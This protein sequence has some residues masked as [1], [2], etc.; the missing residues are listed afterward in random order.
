MYLITG[1]SG[2]LGTGLARR[3][4]V[5]CGIPVRIF[6]LRAGR[7]LPAGAEFFRGDMREPGDVARAVEGA[8]T[9]FHLASFLPCARAGKEFYRVNVEGT[10]NLMEACRRSGVERVVY[11]SSSSVYGLPAELPLKEDSPVN[12]AG[13][14]GRSKLL[15]EEVC[16]GYASCGIAVPV[17]RPRFIVGPGRLGLLE[18]IFGWVR[19]N[20]NVYTIGRGDNRFQMVGVED[21]IDAC[22]LA[23]ASGRNGVYNIGA[24]GVPTVRELLAGL[25]RHARSSSALVPLNA[26]AVKLGMRVLDA[27]NLVPFS[28]EQY[29]LADREY[30]LDT[31]KA[32]KELG[33]SPKYTHAAAFNAAYDWYIGNQSG[34]GEGNIS[35]HPPEKILRLLKCFS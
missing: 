17:I 23:A 30:I 27:L 5:S 35:D 13:D 31:S 3:L 6:D 10:R 29:L 1:G 32:K 22:L 25:I 20:R 19:E 12:P 26:A 18:V 21:L 16:R 9:V 24:D 14:Y 4:T 28:R 11:V 8:S 15:G 2:F 33:W 34:R 7:D